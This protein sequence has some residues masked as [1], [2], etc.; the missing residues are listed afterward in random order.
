MHSIQLRRMAGGNALFLFPVLAGLSIG[1]TGCGNTLSGAKQD[2][3]TDTQKVGAAANQA[4]ADTATAAHN[5][6]QA[7]KAVP[8]DVDS[9][10]A[11]TPEVK[12]AIIRDPVLNDPRNLVNV[13]SHDHV[14]HLTG[15][16]IN[17]NMKARA[18]EDAQAV[19][20]RRHPNYQVH[21]ELTISSG[22]S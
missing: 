5:A 19:L 3:A 20:T 15:H 21:N 1:L 7:V 11:V 2:T 17:A 8:Q 6:G 10:A 22:T 9:A 4:A 13:N 18:A 14:T 16:V 12:T